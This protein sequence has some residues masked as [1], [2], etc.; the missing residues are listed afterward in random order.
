MHL[1][2]RVKQNITFA[3]QENCTY[4]KRFTMHDASTGNRSEK[5]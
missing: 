4:M 1:V 2:S 3:P 5:R